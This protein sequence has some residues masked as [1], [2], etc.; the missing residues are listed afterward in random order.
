MRLFSPLMSSSDF[1]RPEHTVSAADSPRG[2]HELGLEAAS[3]ALSNLPP[4]ANT[5]NPPVQAAVAERSVI[6]GVDH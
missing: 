2:K 4:R 6:P 1:L 3:I 5:E